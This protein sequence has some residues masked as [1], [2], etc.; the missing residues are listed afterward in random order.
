MR[1][2]DYAK[3]AGLYPPLVIYMANIDG[4]ILFPSPK[5]NRNPGG[6]YMTKKAFDVAWENYCEATGLNITAH[7]LRHGAATIMYEAGVDPYTAQRILGHA[8]VTTTMAVYTELRN[9]QQDKSI[10]KFDRESKKYAK[11]V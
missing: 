6:G 4:Q 7:Q 1:K 10:K 8:Q 9:K 5:S 11:G 3:M 2:S